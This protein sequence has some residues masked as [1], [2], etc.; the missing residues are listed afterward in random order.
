MLHC[1]RGT[2]ENTGGDWTIAQEFTTR[3]KKGLSQV[4]QKPAKLIRG[5]LMPRTVGL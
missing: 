4:R 5:P 2:N 1:A 3:R